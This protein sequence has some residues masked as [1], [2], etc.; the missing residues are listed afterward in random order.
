LIETI[1]ELQRQFQ[2]A[3]SASFRAAQLPDGGAALF[4]LLG[5][6]FLFGVFHTLMPGHQKAIIGAYFLSENARYG[7]GFLAGALFAAFH[8]VTTVTVLLVFWGLLHLAAGQSVTQTTAL[9]QTISAWGLLAV[10]TGLVIWKVKDIGRLRR[11]GSLDR[12]R[13]RLGFD[14]H[15]RLETAYEPLPWKKFMSFLFLAALFPCPPSLF[16]LFFSLRLGA[17]NLGLAAVA[18]ISIGMAATLTA[19]ALAVIAS[20]KA[21]RRQGRWYW[22]FSAELSGLML[23]V[24]FAFFLIPL[25]GTNPV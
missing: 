11:L 24:V 21:I 3:L 7:Q 6:A 1:A 2:S 25:G 13:Q 16:V 14:L 23:M 15:E 5:F 12:M 20:K 17:L 8:G 19:I 4:L 10:A 22:V 9:T 18:A